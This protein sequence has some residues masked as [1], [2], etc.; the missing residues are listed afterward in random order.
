[1]ILVLSRAALESDWLRYELEAVEGAGKKIIPINIHEGLVEYPPYL[2][3]TVWID[4]T[5]DGYEKGLRRLVDGLGNL[6]RR[7][8]PVEAPASKAK[9][10][11]F[12]SYSE[13]NR[14]FVVKIKVFLAELGY[15]FWDYAESDRDYHS[16]LYQELE[17]IIR[18][19]AA[20]VCILSPS[21]R[22]SK[23]TVKEYLYSEEVGT[24]V[25][26]VRA[27]QMEP[28]LITAGI[29]YIDMVA[30]ET[31]GFEKL[32]RELRRKHL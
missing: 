2:R 9:G 5:R 25:F 30:N 21:W 16:Q 32:G 23:W 13:E 15:A 7:D 12:L 28:T 14:D 22:R 10:Y 18:N 27:E 26:L 24:P 8:Q 11:V 4:F 17:E 31:A 29:P 20:T 1:V 3:M 19:A 6:V